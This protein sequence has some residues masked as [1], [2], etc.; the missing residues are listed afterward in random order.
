[1]NLSDADYRAGVQAYQS[2]QCAQ[3][4]L[5]TQQAWDALCAKAAV[6]L[7]RVVAC[8]CRLDPGIADMMAPGN[9]HFSEEEERMGIGARGLVIH[10]HFVIDERE[11]RI[12]VVLRHEWRHQ[13]LNHTARRDA[14]LTMIGHHPCLKVWQVAF[15]AG[16]D[17]EA[18]S[19]ILTEILAAGLQDTAIV[20]G[21]GDYTEFAAGLPAEE[22][23]RL[24]MATPPLLA[25]MEDRAH[26]RIMPGPE[27][28]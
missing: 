3:D 20:P 18:N 14:F 21:F 19:T 23:T 25:E 27:M 24:I 5:D 1:M 7:A 10:P 26:D 9:W 16:A 12:E 28:G 11:D 15:N 6:K 13:A 22:Y 17:L 4:E 8:A 2:G